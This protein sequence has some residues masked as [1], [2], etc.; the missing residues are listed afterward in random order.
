M[1]LNSMEDLFIDQIRDLYNAEGQLLK[2]LPKMIKTASSPE[3]RS[4]LEHHLKETEGHVR[5]LEEIFEK[6]NLRARGKTC[7]G[8]KGLIEEGSEVL[9]ADGE[10]AVLDAALIAAGQRVEHYEMAGYGCAQTFAKMLGK[11]EAADLLG[12]T[13]QE[14]KAADQKLTEIAEHMVNQEALVAHS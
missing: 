12:Q 2:A 7:E 10:P 3:L 13:L 9:S 4:A 11:Q 5:R 14:E 1:K 6:C 8:M